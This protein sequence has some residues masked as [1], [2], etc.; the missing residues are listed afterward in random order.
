M[1]THSSI[2]AW[3]IPMDRGA[4][5]ATVHGVARS[6]TQLS[7]QTRTHGP[8]L[9]H[10]GPSANLLSPNRLSRASCPVMLQPLTVL[11]SLQSD[12]LTCGYLSV[13]SQ[14]NENTTQDLKSNHKA[15]FIAQIT[16]RAVL[17]K[18][19]LQAEQ[20]TDVTE[21]FGSMELG[22]SQM[23]RGWVDI[24]WEFR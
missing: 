22:D 24:R 21:G 5:W 2:L 23:L 20:V 17:A 8:F 3:R 19:S 10:S 4:W 12:L 18:R 9:I 15:E 7:D 11:F 13:L 6:R 16:R 14:D 1:A